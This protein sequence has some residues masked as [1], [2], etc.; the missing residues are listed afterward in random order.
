MGAVLVNREDALH[1]PG[2]AVQ[3]IDATAAGDVF[4]GVLTHALTQQATLV[5]A[6]HAA[7]AAAALAVM[8]PGAQNAA[9]AQ[10]SIKKFIQANPTTPINLR[11]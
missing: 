10:A 11:N 1:F 7:N 5:E 9:P 3:A 8:V 2:H 4:N 6:I